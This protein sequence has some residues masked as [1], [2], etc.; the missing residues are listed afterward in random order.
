MQPAAQQAAATQPAGQPVPESAA[1][2]PVPAASSPSRPTGRRVAAAG[3]GL[4]ERAQAEY[5]YVGR[6]LRNMA[7]LVAIMAV[8]LVVAV[9]VFNVTGIGAA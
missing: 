3:S 2:T 4:S 7:V 9:I 8:M 1:A 5:H 6:D